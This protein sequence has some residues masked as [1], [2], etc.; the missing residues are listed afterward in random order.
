MLA[1]SLKTLL[2]GKD[3][4]SAFLADGYTV[5]EEN[6]VLRMQSPDPELTDTILFRP[7]WE[8]HDFRWL[9][10]EPIGSMKYR[11]S[12]QMSITNTANGEYGVL[13][14]AAEL[15]EEAGTLKLKGI[16]LS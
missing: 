10:Y 5:T 1:D 15:A 16:D 14:F 8:L 11:S 9:G 12:W 4:I 3:H 6:G 13:Y 7:E 2:T